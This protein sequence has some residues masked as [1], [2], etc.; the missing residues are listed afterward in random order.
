MRNRGKRERERQFFFPFEFVCE[1]G[2]DWYARLVEGRNSPKSRKLFSSD[3]REIIIF[4][5]EIFRESSEFVS[6]ESENETKEIFNFFVFAEIFSISRT[7][8]FKLLV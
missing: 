2:K 8:V 5:L 1:I 6:G 7:R 4:C 3:R